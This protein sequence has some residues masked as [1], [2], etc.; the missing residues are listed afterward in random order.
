M[1]I[2]SEL[3]CEGNFKSALLKKNASVL[4]NVVHILKQ[5]NYLFKKKRKDFAIFLF[6]KVIKLLILFITK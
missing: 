3:K 5:I 1:E 6:K 2:K 4:F